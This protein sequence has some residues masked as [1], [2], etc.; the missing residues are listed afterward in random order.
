ME[1]IIIIIIELG[2]YLIFLCSILNSILFEIIIH[3]CRF[4]TAV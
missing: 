4:V 1:T 2:N 3:L